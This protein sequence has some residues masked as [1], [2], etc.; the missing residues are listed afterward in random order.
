MLSCL[1]ILAVLAYFGKFDFGI[2]AMFWHFGNVLA[3]WQCFGILAMFWHFGNVLA[4]WQC[5]GI[6]EILWFL[7]KKPKYFGKRKNNFG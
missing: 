4:F 2:L 7:G 1:G 5:F 6:L 3:F